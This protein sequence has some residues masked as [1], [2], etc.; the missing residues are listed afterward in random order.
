[1]ADIGDGLNPFPSLEMVER[2]TGRHARVRLS[3]NENEFGP[4]PEVL[5][6]IAAAAAA[7]NRYPDCDHFALR[8]ELAARQVLDPDLVHV[9][10]GIDGLL[11]AISRSFLGPG[12]AAVT[13]DGTY[14][15]F[16]Y[17]ARSAGASLSAVPYRG[18][19]VDSTA[20]AER[21]RADQAAVIYL[22]EPDNPTGSSL[23][24]AGVARLRAALPASTLLVV[25]GAYAEYQRPEQRLRVSD[26]PGRT[27]WLRTF[28]KAYGLAGLRV[29]YAA[30]ASDLLRQLRAGAE[31]YVVGRL[32]ESAAIA[33]L[34]ASRHLAL[35]LEETALGRADYAR[36]LGELG[37]GVLPTETNFVTVRCP[38]P[39]PGRGSSG[40]AARRLV[41]QLADAGI[42]VRLVTLPGSG[43]LI[44]MSVGPAWQRDTA[45]SLM[46]ELTTA[47]RDLATPTT[48]K[49]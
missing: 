49:E 14:P 47:A 44:R 18:L 21:A 31:H 25:D 41:G 3:T 4:A 19:R 2:A 45:V 17:F 5:E 32:A 7:A 46:A 37:F 11:G 34:G 1:V 9:S 10:S 13:T 29:G 36:R 43:D 38:G 12:R 8:H 42:F 24:R 15:T 28:S 22:A 35:V 40:A 20:L 27:L 48:A 26:L 30:G 39:P 23:G 6:E 33:A 16:A